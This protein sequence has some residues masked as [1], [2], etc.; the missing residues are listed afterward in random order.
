MNDNPPPTPMRPPPVD[1]SGMILINVLV[2]VMLATAI[3]AVMIAG[4]D[5]DVELNIRMSNAAQARAVAAGG[6]MSAIVALR[7]DLTPDA[8]GNANDSDSSADEWAR[9]GDDDAAIDGGRFTF[10]RHRCTGVVQ[11]Q[12]S[13]PRRHADQRDFSRG[14]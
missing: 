4:D 11:S 2:I 14:S 1:Q 9:I 13:D 10:R 3:L 5:T 12:Q 6:E 7:R 8:Q